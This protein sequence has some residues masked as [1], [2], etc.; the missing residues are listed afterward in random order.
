M[1]DEEAKRESSWAA[2]VRIMVIILILSAGFLYYYF[3]PTVDEIQGNRPQSSPNENLIHLIVGA[4]DFIVPENYTVLPR[5]R[6]GGKQ[7]NV[8]LHAMLPKMTPFTIATKDV[9]ESVTPESPI[10]SFEIESFHIMN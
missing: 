10:I 7:M 4:T 2:P 9:F 5:S 1:F 6:R 8:K 3:G